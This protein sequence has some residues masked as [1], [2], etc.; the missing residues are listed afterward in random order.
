MSEI[1]RKDT[2]Q[3]LY[4]IINSLDDQLMVIDRAYRI[5]DVND[6]VLRN[7][8]MTKEEILGK[9]C[10]RISHNNSKPCSTSRHMCPIN[11]VWETGKAQ[12]TTHIHE[13][14]N[15][16]GIEKHF[17]DIIA[18]PI[19]DEQGN[20]VAVVETIRDVTEAK[21]NESRIDQLNRKLEEKDRIRGELLN[22]TFNIQ[23]EERKR[24]ARELH[25]ETAQVIASLAAQVDS[26]I[27]I[28]PKD[29]T[30]ITSKLK[31][32]RSLHTDLLSDINRLIYDLRPTLLDDLGLNAAIG[33]LAKNKLTEVGIK[34]DVKTRGLQKRLPVH[35]ETVIFRVVQEAM[36]NI[37]KHAHAKNVRININKSRDTIQ[38]EIVDNGKG[39]NVREALTLKER[40]RGLGLQGMKE[41]IE[42]V[43]GNITINSDINKG[44]QISIT[45]PIIAS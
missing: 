6:A 22:E 20:V 11:S 26:V 39:F 5:I 16:N 40:P 7:L 25:D 4:S 28:L 37:V 44:T 2:L 35:L 8:N 31:R 33:W 34:V 13:H 29:E 43:K 14:Q 21:N 10:Y 30:Q 42:L 45:I 32:I 23:E 1:N 12:K 36:N 38:I 27:N 9:F 3:Y 41:R 19:T 18:S 24:I 17:V 15:G